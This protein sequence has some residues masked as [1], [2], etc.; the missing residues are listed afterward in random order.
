MT[1]LDAPGDQSWEAGSW[2][3]F[4]VISSRTH[5]NMTVSRRSPGF[6]PPPFLA[7]QS[8]TIKTSSLA[9]AENMADL[10]DGYC[11]LQGDPET[12]LIVRPKKGETFPVTFPS[13]SAPCRHRSVPAES[14]LQSPLPIAPFP[15][16]PSPSPVPP[17]CG[18]HICPV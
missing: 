18:V 11:R 7:S 9:E 13:S 8:L 1:S 15:E 16:P 10:I 17:T 12:S 6:H 14:L 2:S 5:V 4:R 3:H